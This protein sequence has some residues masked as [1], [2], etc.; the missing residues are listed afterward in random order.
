MAP[1]KSLVVAKSTFVH[2]AWPCA[3]HCSRRTLIRITLP[4]SRRV[5]KPFF[6][7]PSLFLT[8]RLARTFLAMHAVHDEQV[9]Q[10]FP[11]ARELKC[12]WTNVVKLGESLYREAP[13]LDAY[14]PTQRTPIPNF[15]MAGSYTYQVR[16]W[17]VQ[18]TRQR[19]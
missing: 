7:A 18:A 4:E 9:L 1:R 5:V 11:S 17:K 19:G 16:A 13:G 3:L 8:T 2:S 15:F 6:H 14:R 12:T 10:L